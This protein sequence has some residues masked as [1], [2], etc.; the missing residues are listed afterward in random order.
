MEDDKI[1]RCTHCQRTAEYKAGAA[2]PVCCDEK[3]RAEP[4]PS[5]TSAPHPEMARNA[6][7][8]EPCDDGRGGKI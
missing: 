4:L 3:M 2:A 5:C 1:Y 8:D 7:D 6:D